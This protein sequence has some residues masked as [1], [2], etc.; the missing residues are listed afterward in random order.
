MQAMNIKINL[1][2]AHKKVE[3]MKVA[4]KSKHAS[5]QSTAAALGRKRSKVIQNVSISATH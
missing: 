3:L 1:Q 2:K 5:K 4:P